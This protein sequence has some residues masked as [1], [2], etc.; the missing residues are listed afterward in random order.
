MRFH[1]DT[2]DDHFDHVRALAGP[3]AVA[4]AVAGPDQLGKVRASAADLAAQYI[5][6]DGVAM[7]GLALLVTGR[8]GPSAAFTVA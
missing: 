3:L 6:E 5:T 1:A 4:L 2:I 8:V 7:P